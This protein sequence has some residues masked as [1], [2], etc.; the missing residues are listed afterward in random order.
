M[1]EVKLSDNRVWKFHDDISMAKL[2][3]L[4]DE[5]TEKNTQDERM[6]YNAK[7]ICAF[8]FDPIVTEQMLYELQSFDY[9]KI[10]REVLMNYNTRLKDFL[11]PVQKKTNTK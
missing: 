1:I 11:S 5:P 9:M 3:A 2:K 10:F 7:K 6:Q 4:G 8:S